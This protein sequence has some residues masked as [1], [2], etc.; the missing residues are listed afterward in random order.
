[1][2]GV[3]ADMLE[4]FTPMQKF[5]PIFMGRQ[6]GEGC[7]TF[8]GCCD[9]VLGTGCNILVIGVIPDA[10]YIVSPFQCQ[11]GNPVLPEI[12]AD[13]YTGKPSPGNDATVCGPG[14][15]TRYS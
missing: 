7:Q 9:R 13:D 10:A 15:I 11:K 5:T 2:V 14:S 6:I 12:L 8:S 1:M 3:L 4:Q